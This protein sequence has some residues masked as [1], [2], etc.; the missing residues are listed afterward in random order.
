M[1]RTINN[2]SS[3]NEFRIMRLLTAVLA[4]ACSTASLVSQESALTVQRIWG[5]SDFAS[6]LVSVRWMPDGPYY[7]ATEG[8]ENGPRD[9]YRIDVRSGERDLLVLGA[10]LVLPGQ[11]EPITIERYQFSPDATKLLI[12]TSSVRV[13]RQKTKGE[14]YVWDFEARQLTPVSTAPGLQMF[15]KFSADGRLVGFVRD[16][17][18]FVTDLETGQE[19]QL[20]HDGGEDI[21]NGTSDWVYEEELGLRD[22]FRFSPDGRRVAFWRL[23]QTVI[24]PFYLIDETKLYP[25]LI[26]VRYP[27]AGE[28]NSSV[29]IGVVEI[30]TGETRW[31]DLGADDDIYVA[32]MDFAE[33]SDEIWLTRL[34]RH[35]NRLDLMLADVH[36]G[37]SRVIMSDTDSAWVDANKPIW[38]DD[39]RRF[40]FRSERDGRYQIFSFH[41]D[42]SRVRKLTA[43]EW[44]VTTIH[45]VDGRNRV[46]FT[47]VGE[48]PL[49]RH[50]YRV[51][52]NGRGLRRLSEDPGTHSASFDPSF[53]Y[54]IDTYS[55]AARPPVQ[56][57]YR[58]DGRRMR[59]IAD[60]AELMAKIEALDL[61][62]QEFMT[63]PG[64]EGTPLNAFIIKPP[65]FDPNR[66]YPLLMYV[67]GGPRSQ[68]VRDAWGGDRY[69]WH[70]MLAQQGYLV[71]SVDNRGTGWRG[72]DFTK[73]TYL[74]L[75]T[76]ESA[77]QIAAARHFASL[78]YVD[79][80][81]IGIW[82]WSYGGY[83][84]SL[85]L[86][87]GQGIF[88]AAIS[89][90]P[91]TDWR[92]YDTIYTE[93]FMR[94]PQENAE[95]YDRSAP[96]TYA[97]RMEGRFLLVH[98][99][100]DDNVHM[101]NTTQLVERLEN[102]NK[103]FDLR[104]YPNKTHAI[105]GR[106]TRVNLYTQFTEW[107]NRNLRGME[108]VP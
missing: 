56:I 83:M 77:D 89:V 7:T 71:A 16:N 38:F 36:T 93:R 17:N 53:R 72:R 24:K 9:L 2:P 35:Q 102:A 12:F 44:D 40:L 92:L 47:G 20:T 87:K 49:Q 73:Q 11:D 76:L 99:S 67:Y 13:W 14:Y 34:N 97:D 30:A 32:G 79:G 19:T 26:P 22:A 27:K 74:N 52:S 28:Q 23:D 39:G 25:E 42:G 101:Q 18:I 60:N 63:V 59:V 15:A 64:E 91:V 100:G 10:D 107:L 61:T 75:G 84:S 85:S 104:I 86:F 88:R 62:P 105:A 45:G 6:D 43:E 80:A 81:R 21:I 8:A 1:T 57:L 98:G 94:T 58:A 3:S 96:L 55:T 4:L 69:L 5:S 46:Y 90:A 33:S 66:R 51:G 31:V 82:G 106:T 95:G 41:R 78:P 103:Q 65:D 29:Q 54:Y 108:L 37:E 68:T 70:Q 48:G 50:V